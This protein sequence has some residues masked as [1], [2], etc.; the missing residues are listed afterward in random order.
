MTL[1]DKIVKIV[2]SFKPI[3]IKIEKVEQKF[4][5]GG[6]SIQTEKY[7][8]NS[9]EFSFINRPALEPKSQAE[10]DNKLFQKT[11][12]FVNIDLLPSELV[13]TKLFF[14][15]GQLIKKYRNFILDKD[16]SS[17]LTSYTICSFEDNSK[18]EDAR[19]LKEDLIKT[20]KERGRTIY[21]FTR[22]GLFETEILKKLNLIKKETKDPLKQI[23]QFMD[24]FNKLI[25]FHP[26][27]IYVSVSWSV[28]DL[29]K[30]VS[31]RLPSICRPESEIKSINIFS[32]SSNI[33]KVNKLK[34]L[35]LLEEVFTIKDNEY[36]F[37]KEKA[38]TTIL[39]V[40]KKYC[41]APEKK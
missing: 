6:K 39:K 26:T 15:K 29:L 41:L 8:E 31:L 3:N 25:D 34:Q 18:K 7:I 32:R 14:S 24:Y 5:V 23:R 30:E 1:T 28:D 36:L 12:G 4:Q 37:G 22:S 38:Q 21:N 17:V 10:L 35:P 2:S 27:N 9:G 19:K 20:K 13:T 11:D 33:E 16:L 40:K